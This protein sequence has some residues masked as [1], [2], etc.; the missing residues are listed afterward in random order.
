MHSIIVTLKKDD[1][2]SQSSYQSSNNWSLE[3][4]NDDLERKVWD[5]EDE[6]DDCERKL[7][8]CN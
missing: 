3:N 1:Y 5:L 6:L 4:D 8:D 2:E 7:R